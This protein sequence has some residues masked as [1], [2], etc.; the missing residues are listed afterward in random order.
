MAITRAQVSNDINIKITSKSAE[1]SISNTEDG[2][3]RELI[4]DFIVQEVKTKVVRTNITHTQL[5]NIF[6]TPIVALPATAGVMYVPKDIVVKYNDNDGWSSVG[7]WRVLLDTTQLTNFA[8]QMGG[9]TVTEQFAFLSQ[10]NPSNTTDSF[11]NKD[12]FIT[13][14]ANPTVPANPSTN[15]D[16][17]ITYFEITL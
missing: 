1:G 4:L 9:G 17:Y 12:V 13:S 14:S 5:L 11:F 15:V 2:A 3:N 6:T 16:V 10:G 7:T 8:S